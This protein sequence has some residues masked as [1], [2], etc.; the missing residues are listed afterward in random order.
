MENVYV[1]PSDAIAEDGPNQ[2]VFVQDGDAFRMV[3]V[4]IAYRDH[5]Y[6]VIPINRHTALFPGDPV[7]VHN[8]FPLS[9]ALKG[10]SGDVD[11]HAGHGH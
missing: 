6:A 2:V 3:E 10:G 1:L 4:E 7:V 8:A 5:E 11:P 9:L